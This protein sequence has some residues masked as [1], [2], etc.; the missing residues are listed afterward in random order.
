MRINIHADQ[1]V[2]DNPL[3]DLRVKP[4]A[5]SGGGL[6]VE[7]SLEMWTTI[8]AS[9]N[10]QI[11]RS[12]YEII[13]V[14]IQRNVGFWCKWFWYE[15]CHMHRGVELLGR[16]RQDHPCWTHLV[17]QGLI[18]KVLL[19]ETIASTTYLTAQRLIMRW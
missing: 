6:Y 10:F 5:P 9:W 7:F 11:R 4:T 16:Q 18:G 15:Y 14:A 8:I 19:V 13:Q 1:M 12:I 17:K 3:P 2:I